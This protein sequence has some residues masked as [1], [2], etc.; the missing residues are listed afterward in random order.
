MKIKFICLFLTILNIIHA[1]AQQECVLTHYSSEDGLSENTVMDILQDDKGN[2]WFSTWNGIN[3]FDGYTF[4]TY[5]GNLDNQTILGSNRIDCMRMDTQ[6][7]IWL[8]TYDEN[9]F[10]FNPRT[11]LFEKIPASEEAGNGIH[12]SSIKVLPNGHTWLLTRG[13]GAIRVTTDSLSGQV[14]T[15]YYSPKSEKYPV[16]TVYNLFVSEGN[17]WILSDNGLGYIPSGQ[18][19]PQFYF[20]HA[21]REKFYVAGEVNDQLFF[22]AAQG[23]V[24]RFQKSTKKFSPL[25]LPASSNVCGIE[26]LKSLKQVLIATVSDGFFLYHTDNGGIQHFPPSLLLK[27]P[28]ESVFMDSTGE[29]WLEQN[30]VGEVA[31][32]NPYHQTVKCEKVYVEPTYTDRSRPAFHIHED[33]AGQ[34]WVHPYGGGF[35][36]FDRKHNCLRPFYNSMTGN[37]W[38]FSNKI[39][40]AFS[41]KQGNLWMGTHSKGLEKA[42][43]RTEHFKLRIPVD[44]PYESLSNEVR[45]IFDDEKGFLWIGLKDGMLRVYDKAN[46]EIGYLTETGKIS[47]QGTPLAGNV[48]HLL[49]DS[50]GILWIAT[51]GAGLIKAEPTKDPLQFKLTNFRYNPNDVYSLSDNNLYC[52]YEDITGRIWVVTFSNGINYITE[53]EKGETLFINHRNRLTHYPTDYCNKV[54]CITGDSKGRLWIGTTHGLLMTHVKFTRPE[55]VQFKHY[56]C[57]SENQHTLSNNDIYWIEVTQ[58]DELFMATF[59]GGLNKLIDIDNNGKARFKSYTEYDGLPSDILMSI[60]EDKHGHLW[61]GTEN[62]LSKFSPKEERFENFRYRFRGYNLR[63]CE[64]SSA[65]LSNGDMMFGTNNGVLQFTPD[66]IK[67]SDYVPQ[68][69]F[70]QLLLANKTVAPGEHS[71]LQRALD[72]MDELTL[73]HKENI[74]TIQY[75]A[76]DYTSPND[77]QYAYMLDGFESNWN[78]VG[79]QRMAT[80]TN[81]PKGEYVFKVKSTNADGVWT[82]NIRTLHITVLPSFWETPWAYLLYV[83]ALL[84]VVFIAV[85]IL[86]TIY[87]LKHRVAMEH[88]LTDMKL[89]FFTDISHELRTP[90]TL[91]SAPLE[92]IMGRKEL[93]HEVKEQLTVVDRNTKRMLRLVNQILDFRKI[94]NKKMKMIVQQT[95]IVPYTRSI[96]DNFE[97]LAKDHHMQF[98]FETN[99][100]HIFLWVDADKFEKIVYNLLSN[101]FKYTP[102]GKRIKVT[103]TENLDSVSVSVEDQ[104]IGITENKKKVLFVRF[105]NHVD[106]KIFKQMSTGIGLSLVKDFV[107]MHHAS[108]SV[109]SKVNEGS[110]FK[111]DFLKGKS[112][113][114]DKVEFILDDMATSEPQVPA[115]TVEE[116]TPSTNVSAPEEE[117][118]IQKD[119]MLLVEDNVELRSFLRTIFANE[120]HVVEAVN[121]ADGLEKALKLIPD[122]IISDVMMPVKDGFEMMQDLRNELTTSHIPLI[123]LT[124]KTAIESKLEGLAYGADDYITKPFSATYLQARVKNILIKRRKLQ[125]MFREKLMD[126][127]SKTDMKDETP[128]EKIPEMSPSDQK[129]M[130]KLME[131]M[132]ANLDNG[133]LIVDDL[134]KEMAVSRSVFFKKLKSLTGFAPVEFIREVRINRAVQLIDTG[135]YSIT[136]ISY[137]VGI[138][139]PRYFSKCFKQKMGMTPSE[140]R[141]SKGNGHTGQ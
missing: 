7:Y 64:A 34:L 72:Y 10:R 68:L 105:E 135:E 29:I 65:C 79:K 31:H 73:S 69:V 39:H 48:Y 77:I 43:F 28:V 37:G 42:T 52:V 17:E 84:L 25:K 71:V 123:L 114:G 20:Q 75:A 6:G 18:T 2:M 118:D 76:L 13:E 126:S 61:I 67:K 96:M 134:V 104:G 101:S 53:N 110:C 89:R 40:S 87:R 139:D 117:N 66:S 138:N 92:Y 22:G 94:Q 81:L 86:S 4:H 56:F 19:K 14:K 27:A 125:E 131:L 80:Y 83:L 129:F 111:I 62:G 91:I 21:D 54:R 35:S 8:Q 63:F 93:S 99:K 106:S 109:W 113:Y 26:Y 141:D 47:H 130:N 33:K 3:K 9:V 24:W 51:K 112:H 88:Q 116:S 120:Y 108:I 82:D 78:Y 55:D 100:E 45:A 121:G 59:G 70:S 15:D 36:Y 140:Y 128:S 136:Q 44:M 11:E 97:A 58:N 38:R 49:K 16:T 90:L 5:K 133:N 132:E 85:Y 103:L 60:S 137:M 12:I 74:F 119:T 107:D 46:Q 41:D 30:I 50:K 1:Q 102:D 32:F 122:I 57:S 95:D 124:A 98:V 23:T 115:Q 127:P